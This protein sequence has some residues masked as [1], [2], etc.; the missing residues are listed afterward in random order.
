MASHCSKA[1]KKQGVGANSIN[2]TSQDVLDLHKPH[3]QYPASYQLDLI[4]EPKHA[5][6]KMNLLPLAFQELTD[7][8]RN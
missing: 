7:S 1:A 6:N 4:I 5:N 8:S 3:P 2:E